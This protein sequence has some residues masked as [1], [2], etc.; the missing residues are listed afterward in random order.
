MQLE[1]DN[2]MNNISM[3]KEECL[4]ALQ[5]A[6]RSLPILNKNSAQEED[7]QPYYIYDNGPSAYVLSNRIFDSIGLLDA[8]LYVNST[9]VWPS[10]ENWTLFYTVRKALGDH[11]L[12]KYSR[13]NLLRHSEAELRVTLVQVCI[14]N[15]WDFTLFCPKGTYAFLFNHDQWFQCY[16]SDKFNRQLTTKIDVFFKQ[17]KHPSRPTWI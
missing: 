15:G 11:E 6:S 4:N 10:Q 3:S 8:I 13:G 2:V 17:Y 12:L 1:T 14:L 9:G 7:N 5:Y 16:E